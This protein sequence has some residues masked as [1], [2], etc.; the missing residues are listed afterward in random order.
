LDEPGAS[1]FTAAHHFWRGPCG[2]GGVEMR[3]RAAAAGHR[4]RSGIRVAIAGGLGLLVLVLLGAPHVIVSTRLLRS[5]VND[6]PEKLLLEY[7]SASSWVPGIV[8][9]RGLRV[10]GRDPNVEWFFRMEKARIS[11]S[12]SDLLFRRFHATRVRASGL[13]FRLREKP[14][15]KDFSRA[16]AALLP[17]IP[18][19]PDQTAPARPQPRGVQRFSLHSKDLGKTW[20]HREQ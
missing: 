9:V 13:V 1:R 12:L 11:V 2:I 8:L 10:R 3:K 15:P 20:A 6:D 19:F 18:G 7:D 16:H 4:P 14:D 17:S 5:W